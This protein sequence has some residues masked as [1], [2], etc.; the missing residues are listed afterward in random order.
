MRTR[1]AVLVVLAIVVAGCGG[2]AKKTT[3]TNTNW[4]QLEFNA[5]TGKDNGSPVD[6]VGQVYLADLQEPGAVWFA[7]YVDYKH[8]NFRTLVKY[9]P[10]NFLVQENQFV[11]VVGTVEQSTAT[12]DMIM[13]DNEPIVVASKATFVKQPSG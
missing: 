4:G 5:A 11:H 2:S 6:F 8:L 12:P 3:F 1:L 9:A 7:V 10:T 13:W